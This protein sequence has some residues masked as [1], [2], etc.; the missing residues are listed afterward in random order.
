M[1]YYT[2]EIYVNDP[3]SSFFGCYYYGKHEAKSVPNTYFGSGKLIQRYIKKHG[4]NKLVKRILDFYPNREALQ[5]AEKTLVDEK[6][7]TL[8]SKCLNLH[9]GGTGG[10]WVEYCS[11]EEYEWRRKQVI[12][13]LQRKTSPEWRK[14]NAQQ[15][16]D[17]K[18]Y[19]SA[20]VRAQ[21]SEHQKLRHKNMSAEEKHAMYSKVSDSLKDFYSN[22]DN[23]TIVKQMREH[24]KQ[25]NIETAKRWRSEFS[26]IFNCTP[27]SFR[28]CGRMKE[29]ILLFKQIKNLSR[30]E[31]EHEVNR[32]MESISIRRA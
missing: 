27:E 4:T 14:M 8:G 30:K 3:D 11:K 32:F 26:N 1:Y 28:K 16:A 19:A 13:G 21:W 18:K 10:H 25:S 17:C 15:A 29:A 12:T 31:Q 23:A 7:L 22:E 2:Y 20:E 9:E 6:L 5:E 24:N